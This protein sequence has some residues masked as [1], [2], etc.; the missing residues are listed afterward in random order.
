MVESKHLLIWDWLQ[1]F[2]AVALVGLPG[3]VAIVQWAL[4]AHLVIIVVKHR[5]W[6][7]DAFRWT[8]CSSGL[9]PCSNLASIWSRIRHLHNYLVI[10]HTIRLTLRVEVPSGVLGVGIWIGNYHVLMRRII[11][12]SAKH[13]LIEGH[14]TIANSLVHEAVVLVLYALIKRIVC[15][16]HTCASVI[17]ATSFGSS[18]CLRIA[19]GSLD[20]S[21]CHLL[22][23][24]I[25][26]VL[27]T[28][29]SL[30]ADLLASLLADYV[31]SKV[32]EI[33]ITCPILRHLIKRLYLKERTWQVI[34][35]LH[36]F[37]NRKKS[38]IPASTPSSR[39]CTSIPVQVQIQM[40]CFYTYILNQSR[41]VPSLRL[42]LDE[43][44]QLCV[45]CLILFWRLSFWSSWKAVLLRPIN[46]AFKT[47]VEF[48]EV[49][50]GRLKH[51]L[52]ELS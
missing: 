22:E 29:C 44:R 5:G 35:E 8:T 28:S 52:F 34:L 6:A 20:H 26:T 30:R 36:R 23:V 48:G 3:S 50:V 10:L 19:P 51:L 12:A 1:P 46:T 25:E 37:E 11:T 21:G 39:V 40:A 7:V 42:P 31:T 14:Q 38:E 27:R 32:A 33:I 2:I 41:I 9:L 49:E 47:V 13:G 4:N 16:E 17:D 43:R 18:D 45:T 15:A 24:V